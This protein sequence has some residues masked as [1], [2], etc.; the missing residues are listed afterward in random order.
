MLLDCLRVVYLSH[1]CPITCYMLYL[2]AA[3]R[4]GKHN[5]INCKKPVSHA[6]QAWNHLQ[7][8]ESFSIGRPCTESC[9][10]KRQCGIFVSPA[11]L[12][13]AHEFSYGRNTC[14]ERRGAD[15]TFTYKVEHSKTITMAR[16]RQLAA[17]SVSIMNDGSKRRVENLT[18]CQHGPVCQEYWAA[19]YGIPR[20][21]AN[22]LM[23]E[24]RS[25]RLSMEDADRCVARELSKATHGEDDSMAAE[26]TIEWWEVWLSMEDQ[27]PNEAAIQHRTVVWQAVYDVEY[28]LDMQWWGVCRALSRSRWL[29]LRKV[30]LVNLSIQFFGH[31][32]GSPQVPNAMLS[33]VQ[34]PSHSNFGMCTKCREMKDAWSRYRR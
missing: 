26:V 25:G 4:R 7:K 11:I 21:T 30:A 3:H 24:A 28:V 8:V 6:E 27:M 14:R 20:G 17:S 32:E 2:C 29:E 5:R 19:A 10:F 33:L 15:N 13:G 22:I 9:A 34:R 23:A 31:V 16:W 18:V 12:L 1:M